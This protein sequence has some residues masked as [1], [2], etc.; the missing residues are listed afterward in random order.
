[1]Q[2]LKDQRV[3]VTGGSRGLGLGIVEALV[4]R[5]AQVTVV[6]RDPGRLA[7]VQHRLGVRITAGD[8]ADPTVAERVIRDVKPTVLVLNAGAAPAMALIHE[9]SWEAFSRV[10]D[11]DVKAGFHW[12]QAAIRMPL[13]PA[14]RVLIGSSGA[15]I[16]GSPLSGGYAGAKRM[17][18]MM[19]SY[20][21]TASEDLGLGI[22]FQALVPRQMIGDTQ[23]GR[24]AAEIYAR[25]K[26]VTPE[27]FLAGF[28]APLTP[29][30]V[31]EHVAT[32][33]TDPQYATG[34]A[35]GVKG[36]LGLHSLDS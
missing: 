32:L 13:A 25:R 2:T 9:L 3:V 18:W 30:Q 20:A 14:S 7:E 21:N 27:A 10:W 16:A 26:G 15:A 4:A 12:I 19:A 24:A 23:L 36:D 29:K 11:T 17:L 33:L 1:M 22:K 34:V 5:N 6:A 35:F 8:I 28:G 31:G